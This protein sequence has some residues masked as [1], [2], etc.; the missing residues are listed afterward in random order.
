MDG[1][2][3]RALWGVALLGLMLGGCG[4]ATEANGGDITD[5]GGARPDA[6]TTG[7]VAGEPTDAASDADSEARVTKVPMNHRAVATVCTEPRSAVNANAQSCSVQFFCNDGGCQDDIDCPAGTNGRCV[8]VSAVTICANTSS[9]SYDACRSDNDCGN[10]VASN[11]V[12]SRGV[13]AC[14]G[15]LPDAGDLSAATVCLF[16][17]CQT[18]ADC[19]MGG[20]CSPSPVPGCGSTWGHGYFC[21]TPRD[22]CVD[23]AD[24]SQGNAYC[25]FNSDHWICS[26]GMCPDG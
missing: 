18:D 23:N 1:M 25:A 19:G 26:T 15:S 22:E 16:G 4:G 10:G 5:A 13:C 9:C 20:Y 2:A 7:Q 21:H 12:Q 24:C 6:N 8:C 11:G 17:N 3:E 14:R